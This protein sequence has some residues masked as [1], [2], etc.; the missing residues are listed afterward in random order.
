MAI[1]PVAGLVTAVVTGG[2]A[3][4]PIPPNINGGIITNPY[5]NTDQGLSIAEVLYVDIVSPSGAT[6]AGNGT[7]F[8]LQP[9]QSW[10]AIPGQSTPTSVNA[11]TSGHKFTCI[12]W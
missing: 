8:A 7:T 12:F 6:L 9:G 11:V 1:N 3:V 10:T 4:I 5:S 2:Q